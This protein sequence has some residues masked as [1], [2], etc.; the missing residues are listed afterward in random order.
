MGKIPVADTINGTTL[1]PY[2]FTFIARSWYGLLS[3]VIIIIN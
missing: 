3:V 1:L 2:V